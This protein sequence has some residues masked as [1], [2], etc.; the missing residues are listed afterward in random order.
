M[1]DVRTLTVLRGATP[2]LDDV[3]LTI[4]EGGIVAIIGPNGAGKSTL[5]HTVAGLLP[6][7]SGQALID[8]QDIHKL[9][10]QDR[11]LRMAFLT[12]SQGAVPRL[13]VGDLVAFGRWPHHRGR[14]KAA[15]HASVT[16]AIE[17]FDLG[18][19][20]RRGVETL[21]GGQKQRAFVAMAYAQ[22]TPWM[23]LDEPLA[24]LDPK[25]TRDIMDRLRGL[26]D[27]T[28]L[29]VLHDLSVAAAYADHIVGLKAGRVHSA[30][31][32]EQVMSS[33]TLSDLYDTPLEVTDVGGRPAVLWRI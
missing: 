32:A 2:V 28:V 5:L 31:T 26:T 33:D 11:A 9:T 29:I 18:P 16:D 24:A 30:G 10:E 7:N 14:P 20:A 27:R 17:R 23:L 12:Q 15:D 3:S 4:P 6:P 19:L 1:I 8:G 25:Y 13:S 22:S 21:S